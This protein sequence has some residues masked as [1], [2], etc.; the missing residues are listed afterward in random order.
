MLCTNVKYMKDKGKVA[1]LINSF[2]FKHLEHLSKGVFEV[3]MY[4]R[5]ILLNTPVQIG[6]FILQ[7]KE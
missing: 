5:K 6:F 2:N 7:N 1:K 3:E 4:E